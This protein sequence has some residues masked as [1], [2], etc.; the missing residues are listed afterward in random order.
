MIAMIALGVTA[1]AVVALFSIR[2]ITL[3]YDE[4]ACHS[5]AKQSNR[6]TKFVSYTYW[7]WDCLTPTSDGKWIS[8]DNLRSGDV[9]VKP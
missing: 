5:F 1:F 3:H 7:H 6:T 2:A 9:V 4:A 8:V